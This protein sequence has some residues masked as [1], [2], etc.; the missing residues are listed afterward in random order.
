MRLLT[1]LLLAG[2]LTATGA[3]VQSKTEMQQVL[4]DWAAAFNEEDAGKVAMHYKSDVTLSPPGNE[5]LQG[6][7]ERGKT[8]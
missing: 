6:G 4:D 7:A 1:A 3:L 8:R 2:C 5:M